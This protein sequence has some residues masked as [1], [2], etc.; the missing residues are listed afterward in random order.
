MLVRIYEEDNVKIINFGKKISIP[1]PFRKNTDLGESHYKIKIPKKSK[2]AE[3]GITKAQFCQEV[4][5]YFEGEHQIHDTLQIDRSNWRIQRGY[6]FM[7]VTSC[8]DV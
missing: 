4:A 7:C 5:D 6:M 8:L 3:K 1:A 2:L